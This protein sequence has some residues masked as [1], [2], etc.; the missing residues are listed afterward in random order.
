MA[1]EK[2][3]SQGGCLCGAVR[4]QVKGRLRDIVNCHCSMCQRLHGN[5]GPHS[6]ARKV[7]IEVTKDDGLSWYKTSAVAQRG[8]CRNCGSSLFWQPFDLDATGIIAG[9]LDGPT[10]L[11]TLG[12][13]FVGEKADF[14]E[15]TDG[16]P[17]FKGL[18]NGELVNTYE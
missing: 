2:A 3:I 5:F 4:Y 7:N 10:H 1:D 6:K 17:Q 15:I 14:Y 9:S 13:I 12:H 18:S 8:F 11:K 16:L